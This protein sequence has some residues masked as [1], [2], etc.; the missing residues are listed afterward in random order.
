MTKCGE[1]KKNN[2]YIHPQKTKNWT[3]D[4]H[5]KSISD[6]LENLE[7]KIIRKSTRMMIRNFNCSEARLETYESRGENT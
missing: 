2:S 5:K 7:K 6:T 3:K 4:E 1:T